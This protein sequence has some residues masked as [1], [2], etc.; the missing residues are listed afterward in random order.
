[1][2][3]FHG[4]ADRREAGRRLANSLVRFAGP[5]TLVLALP[6]GGVPVGFEVA[7]ALGAELDV[8]VVRKI[9][10]PFH[11]EL[12]IGAIV[13][14]TPPKAVI[15]EELARSVGATT[16]YLES[17]KLKQIAEIERRKR[18]Y[19]GDRPNP[20]V[21]GRTVIVVDDGIATGGTVKAALRALRA[22]HPR[23][24]IL[25]V[26]VA[27]PDTLAELESECDEVVCL[28]RPSLFYAVGSFYEN[29]SQTED[30]EVVSLLAE[31]ARNVKAATGSS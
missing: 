17:Q 5:E 15:N 31:A 3:S 20:E 2:L 21:P 18:A 27:P 7:Q 13:D 22:Q 30:A 4:F 25:A 12:G 6:R 1:M 24:L 11:E 23:R 9:G 26:P 29:F 16:E 28:E 19:R 8:L 14:G 10:A